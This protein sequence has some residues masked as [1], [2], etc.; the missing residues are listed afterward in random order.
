[1]NKINKSIYEEDRRKERRDLLKTEAFRRKNDMKA[2][3]GT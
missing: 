1:M 3:I 2:V